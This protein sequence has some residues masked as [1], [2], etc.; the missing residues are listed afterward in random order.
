[1]YLGEERKPFN[2]FLYPLKTNL[3]KN[4]RSN[5]ETEK[6]LEPR[7]LYTLITYNIKQHH[8]AEEARLAV[9]IRTS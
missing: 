8:Y 9:C 1:M 2:C 4:I 5:S 6:K 7:Q 3:H